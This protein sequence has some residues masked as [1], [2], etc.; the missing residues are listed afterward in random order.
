MKAL[1]DE[2]TAVRFYWRA[3][4]IIS[5]R[6]GHVSKGPKWTFWKG[7]REIAKSKQRYHR[8]ELEEVSFPKSKKASRDIR[9][10]LKEVDDVDVFLVDVR[11]I[12]RELDQ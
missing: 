7:L 1:L 3:Y 10:I 2:I 4:G 11:E 6:T 8:G 12:I 5:G 9:E